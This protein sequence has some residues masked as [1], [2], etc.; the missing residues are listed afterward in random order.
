MS[1]V[2]AAREYDP[3]FKTHLV[4]V[5]GPFMAADKRSEVHQR[6]SALDGVTVI[7]FNNAMESL[8][9]IARRVLVLCVFNMF[10]PLFSFV[11]SSFFAPLT[12]PP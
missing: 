7:D 3:S 12:H 11:F 2:L 4:L 1:M 5:P 6:A 9:S 10:F 8:F